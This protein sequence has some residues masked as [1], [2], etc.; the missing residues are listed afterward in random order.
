MFTNLLNPAK[1][2]P[3]PVALDYRAKVDATVL[4]NM[5]AGQAAHLN[6]T[7][8]NTLLPGVVNNQMGLFLFQ[9]VNELDTNNAVGTAG[10]IT[11]WIPIN[12][13]GWIM[14]L[15]AKGPYELETTEFDST[16]TYTAN[17]P[18]RAPTG[19]AANSYPG[20]G[21]LTNQSVTMASQTNTPQSSSTAVCGLVSR[22][23]FRNSYGMPALAFWP[24]YNP[25]RSGET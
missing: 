25:G 12:P 13:V 1:G 17:Q 10:G 4:Y 22:G 2:W 14:C 6:A 18:L 7:T 19:V 8:G 21:Q 23:Q 5:V 24:I 20:S 11:Q 15:V 9:G 16:Q 3:N